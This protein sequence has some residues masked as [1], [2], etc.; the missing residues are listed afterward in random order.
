MFWSVAHSLPVLL[1]C[2]RFGS[3]G[4]QRLHAEEL[5]GS[6]KAGDVGQVLDAVIDCLYR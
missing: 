4:V 6:I 5:K 2:I 3:L 1:S